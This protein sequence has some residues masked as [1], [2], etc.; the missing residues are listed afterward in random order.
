MSYSFNE[1]Q[2]G[3]KFIEELNRSDFNDTRSTDFFDSIFDF[4]LTTENTLFII[5]GSDSGLLLPYL[6][7]Q[8]LGRG[9]RM[10]VVE[11][12]DIYPLIATEYRGLLS[13][14]EESGDS[15]LS[16]HTYSKWRDEVFDGSDKAWLLGGQFKIVESNASA[17]DY[18]RLYTAIYR[19]IKV[20]VEERLKDVSVTLNRQIFTQMQFRN[21]IDSF[22]PLKISS[23]FG[24]DKTAVVLGGG[25][26]L[27][28]HIDWVMENRDKLFIL[29]VSRINSRLIKADLTPDMV[30]S[31]D[32]FDVS[33][34]VSKQGVLWTDV[35]LVY[36]YHVS[37]KLL[38]QWQGPTFY[39]GK[40][41]PWHGDKEKAGCVASAGPTVGHTAVFVASQ[42][43]FSS[44]LMSGID[45]CFTSAATTHASDSPEQMIQ[46]MPSLCDAQVETYSNRLAGTSLKLKQGLDSLEDLGKLINRHKPTLFNLSVEAASCP[47][48]PFINFNELLLPEQ[49]PVFAEHAD[50]TVRAV[51]NKE[52]SALEQEFNQARHTFSKMRKLCA[53]A[54]DCVVRMHAP[55]AGSD[56]ARYSHKL[57]RI[58]KQ[59]EKDYPDYLEAIMY[60]N[61]AEF[62]KTT[63]PTEFS[64]MDSD[65]LVSWGCHYYELISKGAKSM[66]DYIDDSLPR[67]QLRRDEINESI[68]VRTLMKAWKED[69]TPGRLLRWKRLH[70]PR[71]APKDRA[72]V[73]RSIGKFRATLNE[74]TALLK[75]TLSGDNEQL[76]QVM[77]SLIFLAENQKRDELTAIESKLERSEWP[78]NALRPCVTGLIRQLDN[79]L[80]TAVKDFEQTVIICSDRLTDIPDSLPSMLRLLEE[81]LVR[82]TNCFIKLNDQQSALTTLGMLCEMLPSYVVSYTKMLNICGQADF[83][84]ELLESYINLYPGHKKAQ[85]LLQK[86]K[87]DAATQTDDVSPEYADTITNVV[88]AI[89]GNPPKRAA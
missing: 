57:T 28:L 21:A 69:A 19:S 71:V 58:R 79:D 74:P 78:Y 41:L 42:L 17:V 53:T 56:A 82:M 36:N 39:L 45:F 2:W 32:P 55:D 87:P 38:Q 50:T 64:E 14:G 35:P 40:R 76:D 11:H 67:L 29:A 75:E 4:E 20:A 73:Q 63:S 27:D 33:Y 7:K 6:S 30:L 66:I 85:L 1:N 16:L 65:E 12:D 25:P 48:I 59:I 89:M 46:T 44:I 9:S 31:V 47:S 34:E 70:W 81:A 60:D 8:Q 23:S 72:W 10:V 43:G 15:T 49:K 5:V 22:T 84:I 26:S 51:T 24:E 54:S 86:I 37:A 13:T 80:N 68:D 88:E 3:E 62:S 77:K 18:S 83:A 52:I 61:G